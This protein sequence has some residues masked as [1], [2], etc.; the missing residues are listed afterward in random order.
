[1]VIQSIICGSCGITSLTFEPF[2]MLCIAIPESNSIV[3]IESCLTNYSA[4][5][6][7][8]GE[9]KYHCINCK[10]KRDAVQNTYLWES[11][12]ILVIHLKRFNNN[13]IGSTYVTGRISTTISFPFDKL[14]ISNIISPHT[15]SNLSCVYNLYGIVNQ[16]GSLDGG[17]YMAYC[18]NKLNNN[19]YCFNDSNVRYV[20]PS[21]YDTMYDGAYLLFYERVHESTNFD[22]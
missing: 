6:K 4:Q 18:K 8:V 9:D 10:Q 2:Y 11:P 5:I 21:L 1:M 3:T 22:I 16:S 19:W 20:D 15:I 12:E 13:L 14:D 17:H 7:L